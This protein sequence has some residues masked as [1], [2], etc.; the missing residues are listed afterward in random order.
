MR[1]GLHCLACH[2]LANDR[3]VSGL[4]GYGDDG[5]A[6]RLFN[7]ARY[8]GNGAAST[9]ARYEHIDAALG[10]VPDFWAGRFFV[11]AWVS[12]VLELLQQYIFFGVLLS[13]FRGFVDGA[14]HAFGGLG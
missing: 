9:N 5:F 14:F 2:G 8:P 11:D 13:Q 6:T 12:W 10:V 3:R 1:A 4:N 7:V